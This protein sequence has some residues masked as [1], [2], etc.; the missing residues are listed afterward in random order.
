MLLLLL[1]IIVIFREVMKKKVK[2]G[3]AVPK[4]YEGNV[5]YFQLVSIFLKFEHKL[6]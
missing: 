3:K 4:K 5:S 2:I 6:M 1:L